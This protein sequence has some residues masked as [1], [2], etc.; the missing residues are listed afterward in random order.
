MSGVEQKTIQKWTNLVKLLDSLSESKKLK[1]DSGSRNNSYLTSVGSEVIEIIHTAGGEFSNAQV[2]IEIN[3]QFGDTIDRFSDEDLTPSSGFSPYQF[4]LNIYRKIE[5]QVS[6]ADEIL[7]TILAKL[8][9]QEDD[10]F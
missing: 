6:G 2:I 7:D 4:M 1:W 3:D 9:A 5:R 10:P 8:Q